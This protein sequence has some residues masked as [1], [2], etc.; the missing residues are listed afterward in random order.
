M[1]SKKPMLSAALLKKGGGASLE[2]VPQRQAEAQGEP[3]PEAVEPEA[4]EVKA[5]PERK[6][7]PERRA[8][9]KREPKP[10]LMPLSFRVTP[11]FDK[12]FRDYAKRTDR[13]LV[14]LLQRSLEALKEKEGR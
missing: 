11:E 10:E 1:A 9:G 2:G 12:E 14:I 7:E 8:R 5:E 4:A 13:S 6:P 3:E